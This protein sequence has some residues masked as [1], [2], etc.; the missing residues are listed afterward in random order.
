ME[1]RDLIHLDAH[2]VVLLILKEPL[3]ELGWAGITYLSD[4]KEIETGAYKLVNHPERKRD[5]DTNETRYIQK[6]V[7]PY[8]KPS[9]NTFKANNKDETGSIICKIVDRKPYIVG[10]QISNVN[11]LF[12]DEELIEKAQARVR[13]YLL[14][15][16][17]ER[18]FI[19]QMDLNRYE[20]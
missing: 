16:G 1:V 18:D 19:K 12:F 10:V 11:A 3:W 17:R 14:K 4:P 5:L 7:T 9:G 8:L 6:I 20:E 15:D 13:N 2:H